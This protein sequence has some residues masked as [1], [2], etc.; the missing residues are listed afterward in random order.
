M[1]ENPAMRRRFFRYMARETVVWFEELCGRPHVRIS[2]V[3]KLP[4]ERLRGVVPRIRPG[5]QIIPEQGR[6]CA[7]LA[8]Q[9]EMVEV[10]RTGEAELFVFN[11]FNGQKRL[12]E[13]AQELGAAMSWPPERSFAFVREFFLRL[14][15][16]RICVPA[17]PLEIE[18]AP[19]A[20]AAHSA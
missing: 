17:Q 6:V 19:A 16:M 15:R 18:P 3:A 2:D 13:I 1:K 12:E 4:P 8:E 11:R 9:A 14:L 5:V 7:R 10:L 20:A